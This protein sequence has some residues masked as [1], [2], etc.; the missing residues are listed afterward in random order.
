[1][2]AY[3]CP[4]YSA[5]PQNIAI[6]T[7]ETDI[8]YHKLN[9]MIE[10]FCRTLT[11]SGPF[12]WQSKND[13]WEIPFLLACFRLGKT[14][15]PLSHRLPA[16]VFEELKHSIAMPL[17][18][19]H[20][21]IATSGSS[22]KR[23]LVA[24]SP[25]ALMASAQGAI[26]ALELSEGDI[27]HLNLSLSHV[28]GIGTIFRTFVAGATLLL[29]SGNENATH[30][31]IVATQLYRLLK[32]DRAASP[33]WK[34][35]LLGGSSVSEEILK[36][37]K[38]RSY[39]IAVSYGLTESGSIVTLEGKV[40]PFRKLALSPDQEI[41]V[42]GE[43]LFSGYYPTLDYPTWHATSDIGCFAPDGTLQVLGRK[44]TML[45]SGGENIFPEEIEK[46]FGELAEVLDVMVVTKPCLE[47]G[48][49]PVAFVETKEPLEASLLK[50][51]LADKLEKYKIP[52]DI[53]PM[54]AMQSAGIKHSR[55]F[56]QSYYDSLTKQSNRS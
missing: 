8:S 28:S 43:T 1:M 34:T 30:I 38:E 27:Y 46:A 40:L 6:R 29:S 36:E 14:A 48:M 31:S 33:H 56:L 5:P 7:E 53:L 37:A 17:D 21:L 44:D 26:G 4:V 15:C 50:T 47:Y 3:I 10:N 52:Q 49:R 25:Q 22:G 13:L 18:A 51:K 23:K 54:P 12:V 9:Q 41:L 45:I 19:A 39:P 42:G 20:L 2:T 16:A 35:L 11:D 32:Q 55:R 24:L